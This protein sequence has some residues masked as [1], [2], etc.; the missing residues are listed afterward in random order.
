MVFKYKLPKIPA[1]LLIM[2]FTFIGLLSKVPVLRDRH[3]RLVSDEYFVNLTNLF[4]QL[5]EEAKYNRLKLIQRDKVQQELTDLMRK[6][7]HFLEAVG[8]QDDLIVIQ[9]SGIVLSKPR[10]KTTNKGTPPVITAST[11][12][13]D[14]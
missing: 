10:K 3:D 6:F 5:C 7:F 9:E 13:G 4:Q 2:A 11:E 8:D 12:A 14:R 1:Q